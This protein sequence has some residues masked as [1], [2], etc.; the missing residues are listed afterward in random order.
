METEQ[1]S[2]EE[3][4]VGDKIKELRLRRGMSLSEVAEK[5][6]FSSAFLSQI[7]NHMISPPL[8][9]LVKLAM[10]L[11]VPLGYFFQEES[12]VSFVIV[13][14][15]EGKAVSRVASKEGVR[16]GYSYE[17]LGYAKKGRHMEPFLVTLEPATKK[18]KHTYSHEGEEFIYVLEGEMEVTLHDHT[19]ILRPGDSLYFDSTIPHYVACHQEK[20]TKI[21]AVIYVPQK[22]PS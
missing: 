13:R 7:E 22:E 19:D 15:D 8:G 10:A 16:Y 17:S 12:E 4:K 20:E 9:I 6:G 11:E 5:S 21:L 18:E 2:R 1:V 3:I 14:K